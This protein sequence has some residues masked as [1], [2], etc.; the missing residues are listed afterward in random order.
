MPVITIS[1]AV[2]LSIVI[3]ILFVFFELRKIRTRYIPL[4]TVAQDEENR[5]FFTDGYINA[6]HDYLCKQWA[7]MDE[8]DY[9]S[10]A[11]RIAFMK[12]ALSHANQLPGILEHGHFFVASPDALNRN[13][14][15]EFV[16]ITYKP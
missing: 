12:E 8:E 3:V 16:E 5:R 15:I 13:Y 9:H 2:L 14:R 10:L 4:T 1:P 7:L 11:E 6:M